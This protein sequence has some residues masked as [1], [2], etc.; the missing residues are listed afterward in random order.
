[1]MKFAARSLLI[2]GVLGAATCFVLP[3]AAAL[4]R[5]APA[6]KWAAIAIDGKGAWGYAY[7]KPTRPDAV[8]GA[9]N[10]CGKPTCKLE[11]AG[12][13]QCVAFVDSRSGGYWYGTGFGPSEE[14]A[15]ATAK[16]GCAAKAPADSCR[17]VKAGCG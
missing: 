3:S 13:A 5:K 7:G 11:L 10:G 6:K 17:V 16:R 14:K 15:I 9:L 8:K 12:Q 2:V 1:M 4:F